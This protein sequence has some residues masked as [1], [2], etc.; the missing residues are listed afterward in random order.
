MTRDDFLAAFRDL[1]EKLGTE[2]WRIVEQQTER[3]KAAALKVAMGQ[4]R[5]EIDSGEPAPSAGPEVRRRAPRRC[6]NCRQV[7]HDARRCDG[8]GPTSAA[9]PIAADAPADDPAEPEPEPERSDEPEPE[10]KPDEDDTDDDDPDP[11]EAPSPPP[12]R[13]DRF[14][15]IEAAARVR[16][17]EA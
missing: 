9:A 3:A 15:R 5:S 13:A 16:R 2:L 8:A 14:A 10:P 1:A 7:G 6:S 17:R 11:S 4:L 12:T